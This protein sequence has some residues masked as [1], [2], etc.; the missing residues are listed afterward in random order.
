[1]VKALHLLLAALMGL[2]MLAAPA[3]AQGAARLA[4]Q[5]PPKAAAPPAAVPESSKASL[6]ENFFP[7]TADQR[8]PPLYHGWAYPTPAPFFVY[9][10]GMIYPLWVGRDGGAAHDMRGGIPE[11][12]AIP[13]KV[14]LRDG[15]ILAARD[16]PRL[17]GATVRFADAHGVLVSLRASEVDLAATAA[18]NALDWHVAMPAPAARTAAPPPAAPPR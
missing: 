16:A 6:A 10:V 3:L 8:N 12:V 11:P 7:E 13:H 15:V 17:V 18:A 2:A 1:M 9:P 14:I 5:P 4:P